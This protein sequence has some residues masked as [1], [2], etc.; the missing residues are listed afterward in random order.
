MFSISTNY[1]RQII[2]DL[3]IDMTVIFNCNDEIRE[4]YLLN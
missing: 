4:I 2:N 1:T 3:D